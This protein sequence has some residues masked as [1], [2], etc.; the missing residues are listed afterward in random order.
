MDP[1]TRREERPIAR[2]E[3][4]SKGEKRALAPLF[5]FLSLGL[6]YVSWAG[7]ECR[8]FYLRFSLWSSDLA[9]FYFR[10]LSL[11]GL[12]ATTI[13]DSFPYSSYLTQPSV[14]FSSIAQSCPTLNH[15]SPKNEQ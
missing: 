15:K 5:M 9:L 4:G 13:L 2:G 6:A 12:L 10:G 7:P 1:E 11:P 3:G 14:Q 8:C